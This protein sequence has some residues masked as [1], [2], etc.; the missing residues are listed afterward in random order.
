MSSLARLA[1]VL[2]LALSMQSCCTQRVT[3]RERVSENSAQQQMTRDT[4]YL[5]QLRY[6]SIFVERDR[7][8][9]RTTDTIRIVDRQTE[10]RFR[11]VHDTTYIARTDT[12]IQKDTLQVKDSI[13]VTTP[14][15][16]PRSK[17]S[18]TRGGWE[19]VRTWFDCLAYCSLLLVLAH[20]FFRIRSPVKS[21]IRKFF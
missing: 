9:D 19:R 4:L 7:S 15:Q 5:T 12:L 17:W 18:L 8:I 3:E 1:L 11:L 6:D 10:Y 13:V 21:I 16:V 14:P 2:M 20:L